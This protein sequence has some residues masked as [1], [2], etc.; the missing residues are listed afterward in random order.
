[1]AIPIDHTRFYEELKVD[2]KSALLK[3]YILPGDVST[4]AWQFIGA[5]FV[6]ALVFMR[7][8]PGEQQNGPVSY[9]GCAFWDYIFF[10]F[11]WGFFWLGRCW[12]VCVSQAD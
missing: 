2:W 3:G 4:T 10:P 6:V 9:G 7:V 11:F 12:R 5:M 1:M 8:L